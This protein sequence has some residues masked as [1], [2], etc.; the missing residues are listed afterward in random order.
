MADLIPLYRRA[1]EG[2][3]ARVD[4]IAASQ[5]GDATPCADWDVRTLVNHL[6]YENRW[7]V[8]LLEGQTIEQV[9]DQFEG[10]LV[11]DDPKAA[12]ADASA[13]SVAAVGEPG[14]TERTVHLSFG[15]TP[16]EEYLIQLITDHA[17][18]GWDLARGTGGD[19]RIDP[20]LVDVALG[21]LTPRVDDWRA[22]GAFGPAVAVPD[23]ADPQTRLLGITG[24]RA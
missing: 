22:A 11:G 3:A 18:H 1:V 24:R 14:V 5:W 2:F 19:E 6:V 8:P 23:D 15:D 7:A 10:D 20:E 4:A 17:V 21:Y 12:W 13:A 9:G 16:A